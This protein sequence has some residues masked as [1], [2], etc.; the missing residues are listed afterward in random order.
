MPTLTNTQKLFEAG[1][2]SE[3][4]YVLL[5]EQTNNKLR[6]GLD[7]QKE[8]IDRLDNKDIPIEDR[9]DQIKTGL[10]AAL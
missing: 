7:I 4:A 9:L 10:L 6:E 2:I 8:L 5:I 1:I 3:K